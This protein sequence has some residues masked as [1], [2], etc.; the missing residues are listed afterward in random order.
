VDG[1]T[2]CDETASAVVRLSFS[3]GQDAA[4]PLTWAQRTMWGPMKWFGQEANQF[5][6]ARAL[7]LPR[8]VGQDRVLAVLRSL[9]EGHQTFRTHFV[10]AGGEPRQQVSAAG[11]YEINVADDRANPK[12]ASEAIAATLRRD[13]FDHA[14]EWPLRA[15]YVVDAERKA[16]AVAVVGS[17]L[18][19]DLWAFQRLAA[20][21]LRLLTDEE[22][23]TSGPAGPAGTPDDAASQPLE[24]AAYQGSAAGER[25]NQRG[26]RH[27]ERGLSA[28]PA[29]MFD[30]PRAAAGDLP[31]ERYLLD[32]AAVT[33]AAATLAQR[34]GTSVPTVLLC[35]T[36]LAL[37]AYQAHERCALKLIAGNRLSRRQQG[38]VALNALDAFLSAPIDDTDLLTAIKRVHGLALEAY[39]RAECDPLAVSALIREVGRRRGVSFDLSAYFNSVQT[40]R[41]WQTAAADINPAKLAELR[42]GSLF[43]S[44]APLPKSDM[45][46]FLTAADRGRGVCRLHLLV[47][48]AYL[49]APVGETILRGIETL[50]CDAVAGEVGTREVAARTGITPV[51][52]GQAWVRTPVGWVDLEAVGQLVSDAAPGAKVA[53]FAQGDGESGAAPGI[54]AYVAGA[55]TPPPALHET[56]LDLLPGRTGVAAPREYVICAAPPDGPSRTAWEAIPGAVYSPETLRDGC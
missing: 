53:V 32:S 43:S 5:N 37:T 3:T 12:E 55:P 46:F 21:L 4:A 31:I 47:D 42:G 26:L 7:V 54:T 41:D 44:L 33:A 49:P 28:A 18:A 20:L 50:L 30:L 15:G 13:A 24:Q 19:F 6:L 51:R 40:G 22:G 45:K 27:W 52:R 34:T 2:A 35:S 9:I 29:S 25:Q 10:E 8:P 1:I 48:A 36:A 14:A 11:D 38:L 17:H 56:V 16:T 23:V 39:S